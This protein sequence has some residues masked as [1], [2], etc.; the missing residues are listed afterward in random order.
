MRKSDEKTNYLAVGS[1]GSLRWGRTPKLAAS[2]LPKEERFTAALYSVC[3]P[4]DTVAVD[5]FGN[6]VAMRGATV[7]RV[8]GEGTPVA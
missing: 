1:G 4:D 2:R 3:G 5:C 7:T 6:V 8:N